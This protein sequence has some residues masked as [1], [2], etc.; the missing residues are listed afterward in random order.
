MGNK[1][2]K[3][4]QRKQRHLPSFTGANTEPIRS[5]LHHDQCHAVI[6]EVERPPSH[7]SQQVPNFLA[8]RP[9]MSSQGFQ[10]FGDAPNP[11]TFQ[12][13]QPD[14]VSAP[15]QSLSLSPQP[16]PDRFANFAEI[17]PDR[18]AFIRNVDETKVTNGLLENQDT[19]TMNANGFQ[20][21]QRNQPPPQQPRDR[22]DHVTNIGSTGLA[23]H[24]SMASHIQVAKPFVFQQ[25]IEGCLSHLGVAQN[26][27]D[28]IRLAGVRWI[29]DV[30]RALKLYVS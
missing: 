3:N 14:S 26:R 15:V 18:S 27:E 2:K 25:A 5:R 11:Y 1:S 28:S 21:L 29:D 6:E 24:G 19:A 20:T 12:A 13:T 8:D 30:R 17:H 9:P 10:P 16:H 22:K 7:Q 4:K 23:S